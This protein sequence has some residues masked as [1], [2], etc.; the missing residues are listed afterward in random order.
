M[1][2]ACIELFLQAVVNACRNGGH[3]KAAPYP[4]NFLSLKARH[5]FEFTPA[6][7]QRR[8]TALLHLLRHRSRAPPSSSS[9]RAELRSNCSTVFLS[10]PCSRRGIVRRH[11]WRYGWVRPR[12]GAGVGACEVVGEVGLPR[13]AAHWRPVAA[14]GAAA[15]V[16]WRRREE[17]GE[18]RATWAGPTVAGEERGG[19]WAGPPAVRAVGCQFF[20]IFINSFV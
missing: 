16:R 15:G 5:S 20:Y 7:C 9:R 10:P 2:T 14:Q 8:R 6:G 13:A 12:V 18:E 1:T 19:R 4:Q 3:I 11:S 17:R